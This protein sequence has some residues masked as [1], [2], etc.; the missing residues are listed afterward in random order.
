MIAATAV[1]ELKLC[2]YDVMSPRLVLV[3]RGFD[4]R[5]DERNLAEGL[6]LLGPETAAFDHLEDGEEEDDH[7][8]AGL[9]GLE[10]RVEPEAAAMVV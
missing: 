10:K 6:V 4:G 3:V 5:L 8:G 9:A 7:L 2:S 1:A